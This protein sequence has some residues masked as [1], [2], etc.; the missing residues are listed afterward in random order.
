MWYMHVW[1]PNCGGQRSTWG[2]TFLQAFYLGFV[3]LFVQTQP[4]KIHPPPKAHLLELSPLLNI[5]Q[6]PK[7]APPA[8]DHVFKH[9]S[10]WKDIA[11]SSRGTEC[12]VWAA[13]TK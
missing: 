7:A 9:P 8:G 13:V 11:H 3:C 2:V 12:E 4:P 6:P 10:L 1:V 5:P